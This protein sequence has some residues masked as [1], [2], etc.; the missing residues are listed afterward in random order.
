[1]TD[2]R[3]ASAIEKPSGFSL[4]LNFLPLLQIASGLAI[5]CAL[6]ETSWGRFGVFCAWIYLAPPLASRLM[7]ATF[8]RPAGRLT[9]DMRAY[10]VWWVLTQLQMLFNRLPWIEEVLRLV[11]GLYA[12]WIWL[13]GGDVS[14]LAYIGPG[15]II[16]DRQSVRVERGAVLGVRSAM[17]GHLATRDASGRWLVIAALPLV[18]SGAILG[19]EAG[20][21]PGAILRR[22][23][24]LPPRR[25]IPPFGEWPKRTPAAE[26][27]F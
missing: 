21:G 1:M 20:M 2:A 13:W 18:E 23:A 19:G 27:P 25:H 24:V 12:L 6:C 15:A 9:Q 11:P 8:G 17:A 3:P 10:R 4:A 5:A 22:G 16:T 26:E 7:L 14:P